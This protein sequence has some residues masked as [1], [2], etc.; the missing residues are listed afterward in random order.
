MNDA[1]PNEALQHSSANYKIEVWP[2]TPKHEY[3]GTEH[4][5]A[6]KHATEVN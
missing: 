6:T 2:V 5:T 1:S 3:L 4:V